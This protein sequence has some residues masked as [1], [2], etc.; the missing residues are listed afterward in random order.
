MT[1]AKFANVHNIAL[2]GSFDDAQAIVKTLFA[3]SAFARAHASHGRQLDQFRADRRA[4]R[5]LLHGRGTTRLAACFRRAHRQFRR[6]VRGRG[7][8]A[9]GSGRRAPRR[10]DQ[11]QRH[12]GAGIERRRLRRGRGTADAEPVHGHPGREQFRTRAVRSVGPGRR[13]DA[14]RDGGFRARPKVGHS[15]AGS[16]RS[17]GA[18]SRVLLQR[19]GNAGDHRATYTANWAVWSIPI[20]PSGCRWPRSSCR[21]RR[22]PVVVLSTAHPAKFPDSVARATGVSPPLPQRLNDLY[23]GVERM[24]VLPNDGPQIRA[25][26]EARL[27]RS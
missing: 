16:R 12:P 27:A 20:P 18:L 7:G 6:C 21:R 14:R 19:R 2:E 4:M 9:D 26:I 1:T 11:R 22:V 15:G 5:L 3:D 23:E 25:F 17:P 13:L 24:T 10:R 8:H